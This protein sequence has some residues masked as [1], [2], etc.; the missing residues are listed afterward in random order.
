M[1]AQLMKRLKSSSYSDERADSF[2]SRKKQE[3]CL[4]R[5]IPCSHNSVITGKSSRIFISPWGCVDEVLR[6]QDMN[7]PVQNKL[8]RF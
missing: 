6:A 5:L 3:R 7:P 8:G 1:S 2:N 4:S